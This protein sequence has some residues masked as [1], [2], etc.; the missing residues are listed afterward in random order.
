MKGLVVMALAAGFYIIAS[1]GTAQEKDKEA[2]AS[3][4]ETGSLSLDQVIQKLQENYEKIETYQANFEQ[5]IFSMRQGR[6][7]SE[8]KGKVLY[9]KPGKMVWHYTEPEEHL[10]INEGNTIWDYSPAEQEAYRLPVEES[11]YKSFLVGLGDLKEEFEISFHSGTKTNQKGYY[12]LDL[13]ARKKEERQV[14]GTLT[15]YVD[16]EDFMVKSSESVDAL[17]N[18]NHVVFKD[19]KTNIKIKDKKFQFSPPDGVKVIDSE[20]PAGG[21]R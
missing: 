19:I 13:V 18:T 9:K 5:E 7:V 21:S 4:K 17:G 12:Q 10:Y 16:P 2:S 20:A 6:V 3:P 14:L 11:V 15:L 1:A 8:G